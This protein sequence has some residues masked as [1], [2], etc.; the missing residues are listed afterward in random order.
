MSNNSPKKSK[1][2]RISNQ[3]DR[4]ADSH[5][6]TKSSKPG[7]ANDDSLANN[8]NLKLI[9]STQEEERIRISEALHNGISQ[10]LYAAQIKLD[11]YFLDSNSKDPVLSQVQN[12]ISRSLTES[13][14]ISFELMPGIL[15][16]FGLKESIKEL[17][18]NHISNTLSIQFSC[19]DN[20]GNLNEGF[21]L[22]IY[23]IIQELI[24]NV[25]KHSLASKASIH[26]KLI[27]DVL[28]I[29][30]KDSGKGFDLTQI[31]LGQGIRNIKNR[32]KLL[33]GKIEFTSKPDHGTTVIV[34]I[35]LS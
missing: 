34:T 17:C 21:E 28:N 13:K 5:S 8:E 23:R 6:L 29:S 22:A 27:N 3:S 2:S 24:N 33:K 11:S 4:K 20:L 19:D 32:V 25:V 1:K 12:L 35:P 26:L 16:D 10:F 15:K 30:V 9:I 31:E 14:R 7:R 18:R